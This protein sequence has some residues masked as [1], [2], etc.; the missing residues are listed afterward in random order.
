MVGLANNNIVPAEDLD[1][2]YMSIPISIS[3]NVLAVDAVIFPV[4]R[5]SPGDGMERENPY[6]AL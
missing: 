6:T 3:I 1:R 2:S 5:R 4:R